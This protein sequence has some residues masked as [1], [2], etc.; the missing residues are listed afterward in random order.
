MIR[1]RTARRGR[2]EVIEASRRHHLRVRIAE[3]LRS[4]AT[5]GAIT[6]LHKRRSGS[7]GVA[8]RTPTEPSARFP[9]AVALGA[10]LLALWLALDPHAPD[11]AAQ[12]YRV[13]LY[14]RIGF[15]VFDEHWYAGHDLPGYGLLFAPLSG[16]VGMRV[17][18]AAAALASIAL[19]EGLVLREYGKRWPVRAGACLFALAAVGDVWSGRLTFALGVTFALACVFALSRRHALV[20]AVLAAVCAASSP[21]AGLLLV[22]AVLTYALSERAPRV[23]ALVALPVALVLVPLQL[24]FSEGGY[25]PYP[26]T[27]FAATILATLAFLCVLP[28]RERLLPLGAVLYLF[29]CLLALLIPTPMGSNIERYGVLLAGPLLLCALGRDPIRDQ[30]GGR[31]PSG[32]EPLVAAGP[33]AVGPESEQALEG[34]QARVRARAPRTAAGVAVCLIAVWIV[35]GPARET[36][37]VAGSPATQAAYYVPLERYLNS[38]GGALERIEVPLTRSHWEAALLAPTVSLARGWEKQLEERYNHALLA[39]GL[40]ASSYQHWLREQAVAYVALPDVPLDP[41]SAREAA[42]V[43]AGLPFLRPVLTTTHWRVYQVLGATPLLEGPGRLTALGHTTFALDARARGTLL[44]RVHYTRYF[45]VTRG[46]ACVASAPGGWTY[47]RARAPGRIVVQAQFSLGRALGLEGACPAL[48][49]ESSTGASSPAGSGSAGSLAQKLGSV[50]ANAA[51][52]PTATPVRGA[53]DYQWAGPIPSQPLSIAA[54]NRLA[55]TRAWRLPGP[56]ALIG[57]E[58]QGAIAGYVAEQAI[59]AGQTEKIYV[60]APHAR[61]VRIDVYRMGWYQGLGG[62]LVLRSASLPVRPQP[63]CTHVYETGLTECDWH[64]TLSFAIPAWLESGVYVAKLNAG[65]GAQS[66]CLF[67]VR[68]LHPRPL[69]VE[70]PTASYEAYN[71]WGGDSLYPGGADRVG[72]TGTNQGVEVSYDR[73][74]QTQTGAGQFF[75][76]EVAIVRFLERYGYPVSYT[77][78]E[79]IDGD[80]GQ[81]LGARALIDIG[82]SE[83]WSKRDQQTFTAARERGVNLLFLS[84]DT[85]AWRVRFKAATR[86]SSQAGQPDHVI[87]AFKE[88]AASDPDRADPTGLTPGGGA[89]LIGSA[90]DGCITPRVQQ[91]GPPVYRYYAWRPDPSLQPSWLF[92]HTGVSAGSEIPGIVGY[93]LDEQTPGTPPHTRT[94]GSGTVPCQSEDEPS[95]VRGLMADTTLYTA[96]SGAFV[97]ATGTLGWLYALS[98]VPQASPDAP[99]A[100]DP[101]VVA[102][103]RNL[104]ARALR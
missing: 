8:H 70:I 26:A 51:A 9:L 36:A 79:S 98:P 22:L 59:A 6:G 72:V 58:A 48:R 15:A 52:G 20:A 28:S 60:S 100:P 57:G 55:G 32:G 38:H 27:S 39:P 92:A 86:A 83:Y 71:A 54:E 33:Q 29:S 25:E 44:A 4:T 95:P 19:F 66:D 64:P 88:F 62:R 80:P 73:P 91:P 11:M 10:L 97:F 1:T 61:T 40:T 99:R 24:L 74:Y 37:A 2:L 78:I 21:V 63:T 35:W 34:A 101:R 42:L 96:R 13:A 14:E 31:R 46:D 12:A 77:T 5:S 103:T 93:E 7:G 87:V 45:T 90:Y 56:S 43:R 49:G 69:L 89:S 94:I 82:H 30:A 50:F 104:L 3:V 102:M 65:D 85:M 84:S 53:Q 68:A 47:L 75:I 41:S 23:F 76:R 67:V 16:L 17:L 81:T 18:A